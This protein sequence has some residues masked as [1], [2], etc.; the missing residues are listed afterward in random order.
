VED[1]LSVGLGVGLGVRVLVA[2]FVAVA[3]GVDVGLAGMLVAV[4]V[5]G[6]VAARTRTVTLA[7]A[8]P[9]LAESVWSPPAALRG[10]V[11]VARNEPSDRASAMG[12]P[13]VAPS[14]L[15][16]TLLNGGKFRPLAVTRVPGAALAGLAD[17][18]GEAAAATETRSTGTLLR[19][20]ANSAHNGSRR[21]CARSARRRP[22]GN[23]RKARTPLCGMAIHSGCS[24]ASKHRQQALRRATTTALMAAWR[25][26]EPVLSPTRAPALV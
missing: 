26:Q 15:S 3:G 2:C 21:R 20:S 24:D 5:A 19:S 22:W 14:Q 17:K 25:E 6:T 10:M 23:K 18:L 13:D 8:P 16:R 1:G 11:T 12:I 4:A 7:C 9:P